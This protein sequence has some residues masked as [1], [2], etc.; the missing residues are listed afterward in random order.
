MMKRFHEYDKTEV[1]AFSDAQVETLIELEIAH[2]GIEPVEAPIS[3]SLESIGISKSHLAWQIGN[4]I[5]STEEEARTIAAM[6]ILTEHYNYEIGY[7]YKWLDPD[8]SPKVHQ[9]AY[10]KEQDIVRVAKELQDHERKKK[11]YD[12]AKSKYSK[13]LKDISEIRSHV[14]GYMVDAREFRDQVDLAKKTWEKHL[15]LADQ[16]KE[17]A[18]KFFRDAY[19]DNEEILSIFFP[20]KEDE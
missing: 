12:S 10:Y 2:K 3:P 5:V 7:E 13:F 8:I 15:V 19:K 9:A 1:A 14:W 11:I 18:E 17:I 4:I 6:N 16:N 20:V